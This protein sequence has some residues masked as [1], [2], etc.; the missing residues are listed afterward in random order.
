MSQVVSPTCPVP[1]PL[2][3]FHLCHFF[4][5][6]A[7]LK[8]KQCG[9]YLFNRNYNPLFTILHSPCVHQRGHGN[10]HKTKA[11]IYNNAASSGKP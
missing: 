2:C 1:G 11:T 7:G 6:A 5:E 9:V 8:F 3:A 10:I 4:Q